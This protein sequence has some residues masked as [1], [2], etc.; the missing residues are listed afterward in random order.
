MQT[1]SVRGNLRLPRIGQGTWNMG[2]KR[3]RRGQEV[4]ALRRGIDRGMTVID[5]AEMYA[6]GGAEEV[7]GEAIRG[8]RDR[9]FLVSKVLPHHA[10]R[11][12]TL[13]AAER[14]LRRLG[15]DHLDL[16]LLHWPG[17]HPFAETLQAFGEL[18][19]SGKIRHFGVSNFD[20]DEQQQAQQECERRDRDLTANQVLYNLTR[21]GIERRLLPRCQASGVLLMAYSPLEQG[22]LP[23]AGALAAVAAARHLSREQVALA[24][25]LRHPGVMALP[26]SANLAHVD[27][28][29]AADELVLTD[30]ELRLLDQEFP[31]PD[32]DIP[33]ETL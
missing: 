33:L 15:V 16:Y 10:S 26:M 31:A 12:G 30:E 5:T 14:S 6:E 29:A 7:V 20:P 24:W 28:N 32:H 23:S 13:R 19:D 2:E 4:A 25:T 9:V 3:S 21:R 8:Q 18:Q 11:E 22:R 17:P 27:Q 1:V